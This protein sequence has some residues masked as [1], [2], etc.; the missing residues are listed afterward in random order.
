MNGDAFKGIEKLEMGLWKAADNFCAS[1][2]LTSSDY[3]MSV[4]GV[5]SL[6]YTANR[7][8]VLCA[9]SKRNCCCRA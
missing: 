5:I 4:L 9:G 8:E 1:P 2:K 7:L 6:G 3:S